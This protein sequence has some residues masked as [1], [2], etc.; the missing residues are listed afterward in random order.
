M[1][2][3]KRPMTGEAEI[4]RK[5]IRAQKE[6]LRRLNMTEDER[7]RIRQMNNKRNQNRRKNLQATHGRGSTSLAMGEYY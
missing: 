4:D 5:R 6:R 1:S 7:S 2:P 3:K